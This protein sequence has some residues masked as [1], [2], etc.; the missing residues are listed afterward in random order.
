MGGAAV[1]SG[2]LR[3]HYMRLTSELGPQIS[4]F[5]IKSAQTSIVDSRLTPD[6]ILVNRYGVLR[7]EWDGPGCHC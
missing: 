2:C 3:I 6:L 7:E 4:A 1:R 5:D